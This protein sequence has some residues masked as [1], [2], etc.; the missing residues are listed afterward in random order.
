MMRFLSI[1]FA[2]VITLTMTAQDTTRV[3]TLEF[4]DITKRRGWYQ[5]PEDAENYRKIVMRY[6]LKCDQATTQD[7]F[8]C[9]EWDYTTYTDVYRYENVGT[10]YFLLG[11]QALDSIPYSTEAGYDYYQSYQYFPIYSG[12][13]SEEAYSIGDGLSGTIDH[14][15]MD[16]VNHRAQ[17]I[18]TASEL[19]TAGLQAGSIDRLGLELTGSGGQASNLLVRMKHTGLNELNE[20]PTEMDGFQ[21]VYEFNPDLPFIGPYSFDFTTAFV[22]DG[23]SNI[24]I[25]FSSTGPGDGNSAFVVASDSGND[26]GL[27]STQEDRYLDFEG[28]EYV[29]IP[30]EVFSEIDQEISISFWAYGD[31]STLPFSTW[32][33][34]GVDAQNR[35]VVNV[36]LPWSNG[37]VYWDAGHNMTSSYDRID[38]E[39]DPSDFA[40]TWTHWTFVKNA[41]TGTM[42]IFM[43]GTQVLTGTG[44]TKSM[45]GITRFKLGGRGDQAFTGNYDGHIDEFQVWSKALT[46][47]EVQDYLYRSVDSDHPQYA[48]LEAA[49][50]FDERSGASALDAS[51]AQRHAQLMGLPTRMTEKGGDLNRNM[52]V[53]SVRPDLTF[54]SGEYD[55]SIDSVLVT[56]AVEHGLVSVIETLPFIDQDVA[57]ISYTYVDTSYVYLPGPSTTYAPD[58][59]IVDEVELEV[60]GVYQN[61][62][63]Q[64]RHQLQNYVTP[65]GIGLSLG[66]NGFR[67]EY[68]VTDYALILNGLIEIAAGNQQEL[69]DLEFDFIE[70]T[71]PRELL[72][73]ETIWLGDY[74]HAAI[75]DDLVLPSVPRTLR[76]DASE[77]ML[78]TRTTGHWFGGVNNCAEFCPK[79]FHIDVD[80]EERFSWLNW[81]E[82]SDNPV[83]DQGGTWIYDRAGWCPGTF[84][85][86]YDHELTPYVTPGGTHDIDF[87]MQAYPN[88]GGEGNY[89]T[90]LQLFQY[91]PKNFQNDVELMDIISPNDWEF[92]NLY[93][94]I[95]KDPVIAIR[96][97]GAQVLTSATITYNVSGGPEETYEW[98][99]SLDFKEAE[100]ITLPIS[101]QAFW[102]GNGEELFHVTV[103]NPNGAM[104]E[105]MDNSSLTAAYEMPEV[106]TEPF[107]VWF[108]TNNAFNENEFW[109]YDEQ[110][111]EILNRDPTAANTEY[112]DTL[113]LAD[114]C[115]VMYFQDTGQDGLSFFANN[116][117][118]G[119]LRMR[120]VAGGIVENFNPSFGAFINYHFIV[121]QT[122]S[123]EEAIDDRYV[124]VFPN[125]SADGLFNLK[126]DAY[127]GS[128]LNLE[129]RD[130]QGRIVLQLSESSI[131]DMKNIAIDLRDSAKGIYFARVM[132]D[133]RQVIRK[134]IKE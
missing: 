7:N 104:D 88:N 44:K 115:Y 30:A 101:G 19:L 8:A 9:G 106:Y 33:L 105:N 116:D 23:V 118:N 122:T 31:E 99:G 117:G 92:H 63:K 35:R 95:C 4:S 98:S 74:G 10:P 102:N 41:A 71:P 32:V 11:A 45:A 131:S 51:P 57:G 24:L 127:V 87:G 68:E 108:K 12:V 6:T 113:D 49:Y 36:H 16:K 91:G 132:I 129:V 66:P 64:N 14:L 28:D 69:I 59:S 55:M 103:S 112:R 39:V 70:G 18:F 80:G 124:T 1:L 13:I 82:C 40:G 61:S 123:L 78:R 52:M 90:T 34:E 22:W 38:M 75:A 42:A 47:A 3:Q 93:N 65:Y 5:F 110:G 77:F 130:A 128:E 81:K 125:P 73:F 89:R 120:K 46:E 76:S 79:T 48:F 20:G 67:W 27:I 107:Y 72:D 94:P 54:Y 85:D 134:L 26:L 25:D 97:L 84:A 100:E 121:D 56:E 96:N 111:N 37:R 43:N 21:T 50:S 86:S 133:G 17:Y 60:T 83:I 126:V 53:T 119:F 15:R 114:G 29:E 109:I 58:G 2:V 62:F